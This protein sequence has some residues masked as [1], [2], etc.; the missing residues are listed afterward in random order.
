MIVR[1]RR[2]V[3]GLQL[4][5]P[6][7]AVNV[8]PIEG[9]S[10]LLMSSQMLYCQ[11]LSGSLKNVDYRLIQTIGDDSRSDRLMNALHTITNG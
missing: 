9:R 5:G 8:P 6:H 2:S 10:G 7:L 11:S 4:I 3:L 1:L